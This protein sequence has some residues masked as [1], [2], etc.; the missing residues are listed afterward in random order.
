M[1]KK[2]GRTGSVVAGYKIKCLALLL[3][4]LLPLLV[5]A[6][7]PIHGTQ[8]M[9]PPITQQP[10]LGCTAK[11]VR[12]KVPRIKDVPETCERG[13]TFSATVEFLQKSVA[14]DR[15]TLGFFVG[16]LGQPA[17]NGSQCTFSSLANVTSNEQEA[18]PSSGTGPYLDSNGDNCGDVQQGTTVRH[19]VSVTN[20]LCE[21][22]DGNGVA[23][24]SW[25]VSWEENKNTT[26]NGPE[27]LESFNT[28][29]PSKC[30]SDFA[31]MPNITIEDPPVIEV[32][33]TADP[34][35]IRPGNWVT[36]RV[37]VTNQSDP[38]D[39]ITL[40]ALTDDRYGAL[41]ER[42]NSN[43]EL[44]GEIVPGGDYRCEFRVEY[45][46]VL[47]PGQT[48][49]NVVTA[50]GRDDEGTEASATDGA[51]VAL[52]AELP[53]PSLS[54][55]KTGTP[56][57]LAAPGGNVDYTIRVVN[58][59]NTDLTLTS[60]E[61]DLVGGTLN[62]VGTCVTGGTLAAEGV[63]SCQY[64][65]TVNGVAGDTVTNT[66][67]VV[68]SVPAAPGTTLTESDSFIVSIVEGAPPPTISVTK[69]VSPDELEA[70]GGDVTY[71]VR[72]TNTSA[73][74]DPVTLQSLGDTR[75]GNLAGKGTCTVGSVLASG[76]AY[77]CSFGAN[78]SGKAGDTFGNTVT[79][80]A[81]D[82]DGQIAEA[83]DNALVTLLAEPLAPNLSIEKTGTPGELAEPGGNVDY[84]IRVVNTGN[85]DL[86]LTSL[87]DDLVGGTLNGVGTCV[88]GGT[89]AAEGVYSC[90]YTRTVNGVAGDTV[91]NTVTVVA[92][93]PAAPGTTLTESDSF[94]VS[95]VEGA[96]PPTISVTKTVSPD[97]LEAPG[98]DVTYTVRVTN[99]S[100]ADDPVT[101]QSLG[102][103]RY[104][105]L[106]GKGT[107]TVGSVLASGAA[108]ECSFGA[109][110]SGKAGDT[111]GN[112]VTAQAIDGDGQI[113]EASDNALVKLEANPNPPAVLITK[114][115]SLESLPEPGG[116]VRYDIVVRN[117]GGEALVIEDITDSLI[118]GSINGL[119]T[120]G[121]LMEYPLEIDEVYD[122]Q[123]D[124]SSTTR[125]AGE[126]IT[127]TVTVVA[128]V[129]DAPGEKVTDSDSATVTIEDVP[130]AISVVKTA[131]ID[132]IEDPGAANDNLEYRVFILNESEVDTVTINSLTDVQ[133]IEKAV[134]ESPEPSENDVTQLPVVADKTPCTLP[135]DLAP[136][137]SAEC[138]F[139]RVI[140]GAD[141]D[142]NDII[143]NT[144]TA[145]GVDD[146]GQA[147]S[148]SDGA[149]VAVV[150][151]PVGS[152]DV[153]KTPRVASVGEP[154]ADVTFDLSII[155]TSEVE[156]TIN[157]LTDAVGDGEP[158]GVTTLTPTTCSLPVTI[159]AGE[160][161]N[162][163]FVRSVA[164]A[165][166]EVVTNTVIASGQD[167]NANEVSAE[168][169]AEVVITPDNLQL[170]V[171]KTIT[172]RVVTVGEV[173]TFSFKI[174]NTS[175][176]SQLRITGMF[177]DLI[178]DL[179]GRGDCEL[180]AVLSVGE[181]YSCEGSGVV[182]AGL[183]GVHRNTVT[184]SADR[185]GSAGAS[186]ARTALSV[187][188]ADDYGE[189]NAW[190]AVLPGTGNLV[191]VPIR[192]ILGFLIFSL[193]MLALGNLRKRAHA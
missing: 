32:R 70:P 138:Y 183:E 188:S 54:I 17:I 119:G 125:N 31:Q 55:E 23:D 123:V 97:E 14:K 15:Y 182:E 6:A 126:V 43:C 63:Y 84:T 33:K 60:L 164:G 10:D 106:A 57:E 37:V 158:V 3:G 99:T 114:T 150:D 29:A 62:G 26:C 124:V 157:V 25:V 178:G 117:V 16:E 184:V 180:G 61:D 177:D 141:I 131:L 86:T 50:V 144:V 172:P 104:G 21:D 51:S 103:T 139:G 41:A 9:A 102:D 28:T 111:F 171:V 166:N 38:T 77:E 75:Y 82:G 72:V 187:P 181:E 110:Y 39:P 44:G 186:I 2:I 76:A 67:T 129:A 127:N 108:Y 20:V 85:T 156:V 58:T 90:Q 64:T 174:T 19:D 120:C 5:S 136:R 145:S 69:T 18:N 68:A 87:E 175:K 153:I 4:G 137:E 11:D 154:G 45:K 42:D 96:P 92:S 7:V 122:C 160:L 115:A 135:F 134:G 142:E 100:A 116:E 165:A 193:V 46:G 65:R 163:N 121:T 140:S 74:D 78:Y 98:G 40:T 105:N 95:I 66:V 13:K 112:T 133:L 149:T 151:Q 167:A 73:A 107:C 56:G 143:S 162:C 22:K 191:P 130:S 30:V 101:L 59:G 168:D 36:Y 27:A 161:Q 192:G 94:I 147:V 80:Q 170:T 190:A 118:E 48:F 8:C 71:T 52:L 179:A 89:L 1:R 169:D 176:Q 152:I 132:Q 93:V 81:I 24:L 185:A 79:A 113:A 155:N 148:D 109:N 47:D 83:S 128:E 12:I 49:D 189:D 88:T 91:T 146:D 159:G 173:V 34:T 35:E 53:A